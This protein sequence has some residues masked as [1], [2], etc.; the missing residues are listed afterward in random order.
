MRNLAEVVPSLE[1]AVVTLQNSLEIE[2]KMG[3]QFVADELAKKE[4]ELKAKEEEKAKR[5]AERGTNSDSNT[6]GADGKD[7]F[8]GMT[9]AQKAKILKKRA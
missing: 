6:P 9:E 3:C 2:A 4:A 1:M 8:A 7:E 5:A